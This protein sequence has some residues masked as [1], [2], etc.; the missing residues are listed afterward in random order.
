MT[1]SMK[2]AP[3]I[4]AA[5]AIFARVTPAAAQ[6][7][8]VTDVPLTNCF[9]VWA[10]GDTIV[11][12]ADSLVYVSIDGGGTFTESKKPGAGVR[13]V[14]FARMRGG[15]LFAGTWGQGVF[16]SDNLG[17]TWS[18]FNQGLGGLALF[19]Q[20]MAFSFTTVYAATGG[21]GAWSR[22]LSPPGNWGRFGDVFEPN[23]AAN[24]TAITLGG[25]RLIAA[26]GANGMIFVRDPGD[27]E[28]TISFLDNVNIHPSWTAQSAFWT[29]SRWF[30]GANLGV[31][32]S[33]TGQE[34]WQFGGP[35]LGGL[36][37]VSFAERAPNLLVAFTT[38]IAT[39]IEFSP[40][41]GLTFQVLETLPAAFVFKMAVHGDTLYAARTDGLWRRSIATV[42]TQPV[43]WGSLKSLFKAPGK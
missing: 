14:T 15:R 30:I 18:A 21:D 28:W 19:I 43:T 41:N 29:G 32:Q 24:M 17:S 36:S 39:T 31:F 8:R 42:P 11:A 37:N 26:G 33:A 35:G 20:D 34:P 7:E 9:S 6:W 22:S 23:Q 4:L 13:A 16:V 38:A 40:N 27:T 2:T 10:S 25:T 12:G 1:A 5:L 3:L